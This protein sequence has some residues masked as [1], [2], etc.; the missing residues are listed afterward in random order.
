MTVRI[1]RWIPKVRDRPASKDS[2]EKGPAGVDSNYGHETEANSPK[3]SLGKD[4]EV[5]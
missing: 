3:R 5:L 2:A 4:A 1:C